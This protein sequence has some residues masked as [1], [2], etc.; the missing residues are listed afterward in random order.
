M[1]VTGNVSVK[2]YFSFSGTDY[3]SQLES[4]TT[5]FSIEQVEA[6][7]SGDTTRSSMPGLESW[8]IS[9]VIYADTTEEA[10]LWAEKGAT[11]TMLVRRSTDAVSSSNPQYSGTGYAI[12]W[13]PISGTVGDREMISIEIAAAGP[14]TRAT[15]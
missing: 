12:S 4:V 14:L 13:T 11:G 6:T 9:A 5:S 8:T 10:D 2:P 7:V 1:P 15:S 3:S